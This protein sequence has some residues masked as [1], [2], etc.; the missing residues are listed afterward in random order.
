MRAL[1]DRAAQGEILPRRYWM[2]RNIDEG[3]PSWWGAVAVQGPSEVPGSAGCHA[4]GR[5][6]RRQTLRERPTGCGSGGHYGSASPPSAGHCPSARHPAERRRRYGHR[7]PGARHHTVR[8][9]ARSAPW[10]A[11]RLSQHLCRHRRGRSQRPE[12]AASHPGA[13]PT[14]CRRNADFGRRAPA[15]GGEQGAATTYGD[16][17]S[18]P[19]GWKRFWADPYW[20]FIATKGWIA[21]RFRAG[22]SSP[23]HSSWHWSSVCTKPVYL[24]SQG[25]IPLRPGFCLEPA[26]SPNCSYW[27]RQALSPS[28]ALQAATGRA[29]T[30]LHKSADVG[31]I[32]PGR[33]ADLLLL[34]ADPLADIGNLH[35]IA[36]VY[37][38]GK[39]ID[40]MPYAKPSNTPIPNPSTRPVIL[41]TRSGRYM[42][43]DRRGNIFSSSVSTSSICR[44]GQTR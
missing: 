39:E 36:A 32:R 19:E 20:D 7:Q 34:D 18:V 4:E 41:S 6:G 35:H 5:R 23:S 13:D 14:S 3:K 29:A 16:W 8:G 38:N 1:Q 9:V 17:A 11:G 2:G 42:W 31:T 22:T 10:Y 33:C 43:G 25:P 26:C 15:G 44:N 12:D 24:S 37:M 30:V 28:D 27:S 21:A 40:R